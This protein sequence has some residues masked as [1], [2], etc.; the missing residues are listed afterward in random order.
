MPFAAV[1]SVD[2][3]ENS[4]RY[5]IESSVSSTL[6]H[7]E[8]SAVLTAAIA[9][10]GLISLCLLFFR[11]LGVGSIVA[12]LVAGII[13]EQLRDIPAQTILAVREFAEIGVVL[14]LFLIGLEVQLDQLRRLGR[15]VLA[16][17]IPQIVLSALLI[18]LYARSVSPSGTQAWCSASAL[19][20][21]Q[22]WSWSS[23]S[24]NAM[25]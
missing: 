12:L 17:G 2:R 9:L 22:Q 1:V 10:L 7:F 13:I 16:F 25:N 14:L 20:S 11:R 19:L 5:A 6:P 24:T 8:V 15:D 4:A 21:P 3:A 23:C 18:G